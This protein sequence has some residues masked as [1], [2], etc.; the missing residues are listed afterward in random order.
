MKKRYSVCANNDGLTM[1]ELVIA[2][3]LLTFGVVAVMSVLVQAQNATH[4]TSA[5]SMALNAAQQQMELILNDTPT[6]VLTWDTQTFAVGDLVRADGSP[7]GLISVDATTAPRTVTITV[8]W[9]G[10]GTLPSG[11]LTISALRS[12]ATR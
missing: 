5:K 3:A 12:E 7:A 1:I 4:A 6:N 2:V 9:Q 8:V 10:R 11:Q